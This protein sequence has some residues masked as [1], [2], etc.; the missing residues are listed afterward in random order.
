MTLTR[1]KIGDPVRAGFLNL[2][3]VGNTRNGAVLR[4]AEGTKF[5]AQIPYNG[6]HLIDLRRD[7]T[8]LIVAENAAR[9]DPIVRSAIRGMVG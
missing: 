2:Y 1:P 6:V 4:N 7:A 5:Y 8:A 9:F 3:L